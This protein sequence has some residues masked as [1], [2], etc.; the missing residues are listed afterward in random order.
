MGSGP[1]W[2][3]PGDA[4]PVLACLQR[5][6][7]QLD[8]ILV[9]HHHPDHIGG[10]RFEVVD[11]PGH[12]VSRRLRP[13]FR[14]NARS[15]AGIPRQIGRPARLYRVCRTHEYPLSNLKFAWAVE[16]HNA[17]LIHYTALRRTARPELAD[18]AFDDR[19]GKADQ[20]VPAQ[21][22]SRRRP[23]RAHARCRRPAG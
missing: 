11:V 3:T 15:N 14:G 1:W 5:D 22:P 18:P 23:G 19:T 4:Q 2:S 20:P 7:L 16:P 12:L 9:T 13:A 10:H 6:G 8:A 21:A 17:E